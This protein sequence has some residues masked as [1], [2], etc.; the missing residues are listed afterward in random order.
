MYADGALLADVRLVAAQGQTLFL[1]GVV[2]GQALAGRIDINIVI[3]HIAK[4]LIA[5]PALGLE[6][7][8][9]RLGQQNKHA[10]NDAP[11]NEV[12]K[13]NERITHPSQ[14]PADRV[15]PQVPV[16]QSSACF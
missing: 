12:G 8:G 13:G 5:I 16:R 4:V 2:D 15:N 3:G 6:T 1:V 10:G 7:G 9:E 14:S 11:R